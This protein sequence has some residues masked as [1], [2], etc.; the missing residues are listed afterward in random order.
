[1]A[2]EKLLEARAGRIRPLL[3]DK[4]LLGWNALMNK[5]LSKAYAAIGNESYLELAIRNM[6]F[7]SVHSGTR[8]QDSGFILIKTGR[9]GFRPFWMIML[10]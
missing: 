2:R 4:I 3:D 8:Q 6:D 9:R 1:M 10:I 7:L 5:A